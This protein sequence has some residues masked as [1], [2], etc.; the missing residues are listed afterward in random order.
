MTRHPLAVLA[1]LGCAWLLGGCASTARIDGQHP[2]SDQTLLDAARRPLS[3]YAGPDGQQADL[4]DAAEAMRARL[5]R[6][7]YPDARVTPTPGSPPGFAIVS[8]P[9]VAMGDLICTGDLGLDH[10]A[11]VAAA[12]AGPWY[13]STTAGDV[14]SRINRALQAAG[15]LNAVVKPPDE[16]WNADR[17][18]VDLTIPIQAGPRFV[19]ATSRIELDGDHTSLLGQLTERLDP[20]GTLCQPR[21]ATATAARLRGLLLDLGHR[22]AQVR[23]S[24]RIAVDPDQIELVF[25]VRPGP[26]HVLRAVHVEGG[27]RSA[28]GFIATR[29]DGLTPGKPLSQ[30]A[31]DRSITSLMTTGIFRRADVLPT[32]GSQQPD[33]TVPDDVEL[34]LSELPTQ[35]VDITLGY[36]T[37]ERYRGGITYVDAH[38]FGQGLR[39]TTGVAASTVSWETTASLTDP[40]HFGPSS[41]VSLDATYLERIE[42]SYAHREGAS[43]LI[44]AHRFSP[45]RD[46][47]SWEIR[48]GY[49]FTRSED[50][51]IEAK[52]FG[53]APE[54]LYTTSTMR[55]ELR[56]DSRAPRAIDP[57]SG[58]LSRIGLAWSAVPLGATVDYAEIGGGWS[59]AWSPAP[60]LVAAARATCTTRDPGVVDTLPIGERLFVGGSD[61]VRSFT[62]QDLGPHAD[63]GQPL[64]G[65]TSAVANLELRWR[66]F[67]DHRQ[68][69]IATFY[70]LGMVDPDPWSLRAPW[71]EGIGAGLRY[72]TPVGPIRFD[73]AI[74]PSERREAQ[75][76]WVL[77][78]TV[79]FAF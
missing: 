68:L 7:G 61:S 79:G 42:P 21:T 5:D 22:D 64:G 24:Q 43:G 30:S 63:N 20:P 14:R 74:N 34:Q 50:F 53:D 27:A 76:Q 62:E 38:L 73:G 25:A 65:L 9:H 13:S 67:A 58:T 57:D 70:D 78:L 56:R 11:L 29:L 77:N 18:R 69:E 41:Q 40:V 66:P 49:R 52:E 28:R 60:W 45:E 37:Y 44:H 31:I 2:L 35:H 39:L 1:A 15:H 32:A 12:D 54:T 55:V 4:I 10:A 26:I 51:R 17:S 75:R 8:G 3:A 72:R 46:P 59:G 6:D 16:H 36:G 71:G 47:A 23:Y 33:G 48:T 19:I